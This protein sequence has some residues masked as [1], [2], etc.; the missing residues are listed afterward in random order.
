M[1]VTFNGQTLEAKGVT[2]PFKAVHIRL[3][4]WQPANT[5]H[6]RNVTVL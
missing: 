6:V 1:R 5:W 3:M 4:G 2:L